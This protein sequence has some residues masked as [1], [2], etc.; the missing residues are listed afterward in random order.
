MVSDGRS[1]DLKPVQHELR[2]RL[3]TIERSKADMQSGDVGRISEMAGN[4]N[5]P[6]CWRRRSGRGE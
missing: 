5:D 1:V 4:T 3:E 2:E 6:K